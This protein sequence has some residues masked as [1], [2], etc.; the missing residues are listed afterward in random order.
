MSGLYPLSPELK[1]QLDHFSG[2]V[3]DGKEGATAKSVSSILR[4]GDFSGLD[5]GNLEDLCSSVIIYLNGMHMMGAHIEF[6]DGMPMAVMK[7]SNRP[8]HSLV[9]GI[10]LCDGNPGG[11]SKQIADKLMRSAAF[12]RL[13]GKVQVI[14]CAVGK[15]GSAV[16]TNIVDKG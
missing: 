5:A 13:G 12:G 16:F 14:G 3:I 4:C 7:A 9:W 8:G 1:S 15:K 6:L 2:F 10:G 11:C